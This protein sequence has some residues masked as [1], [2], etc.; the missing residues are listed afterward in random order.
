MS[1]DLIAASAM[2]LILYILRQEG[3]VPAGGKD[4]SDHIQ[5][6]W[7]YKQAA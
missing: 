6:G 3:I 4:V 1:R 5:Q 7:D 2:Q